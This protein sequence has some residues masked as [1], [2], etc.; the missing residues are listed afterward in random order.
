MKLQP[1]I[2]RFLSN[3]FFII[4]IVFMV[5]YYVYAFLVG[6]T[7]IIIYIWLAVLVLSI[8]L[9]RVTSAANRSATKLLLISVYAILSVHFVIMIIR[10]EMFKVSLILILLCIPI[11]F[12]RLK[13]TTYIY[14]AMILIF[15]ASRSFWEETIY[16]RGRGLLPVSLSF[17]NLFLFFIAGSVVV[18]E[19][20]YG[21]KFS[22]ESRFVPCNLYK[23]LLG[24][25][26]LF[27]FYAMWGLVSGVM[28]DSI[29]YNKGVINLTNMTILIFIIL[30]L[31]RTEKDFE[32]LKNFFMTCVAV[33]AVWIVYRFIF[34]T[35]DPGNIYKW[36]TKKN[37]PY[38]IAEVTMFDIGDALVLGTGVFYALWSL[39]FDKSLSRNKR[40]VYV[41]VII[42]SIYNMI[43]SY[44]R[45]IW[46]GFVIL[47]TWLI[48]SLPAKKRLMMG[49]PLLLISL[50]LLSG[51]ISK[52]SGQ[53]GLFEDIRSE[54]TGEITT[55][56]G[57]FS[58][59]DKAWQVIK[60]NPFVGVGPWAKFTNQYGS[61]TTVVHS[62][63]IYVWLKLGLIGILLYISFYYKYVQFWLTKRKQ[64]PLESRGF[65]EA[66]FAGFLFLMPTILF[67]PLINEFRTM[68]LL[69]L[70]I[71]IPYIGY[72]TYVKR[73]Q[74]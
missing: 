64:L 19:I 55:E 57:R 71:A 5:T 72:H 13:A 26:I 62:S 39:L 6:Q 43:F 12:I 54:S 41:V 25:N 67:S 73:R 40:L 9:T 52:R 34:M 47:L 68:S 32:R 16:D 56:E 45:T 8:F 20:I 3:L 10:S 7:H 42:L 46:G 63:I 21:T 22:S 24:F 18:K 36:A 49:I 30:Y 53:L 58:E 60:K 37:K 70:C 28:P 15:Q 44:R 11:L 48:F 27:G 50:V 4:F 66:A 31:F 17:M 29:F 59:L 61:L 14:L 35:G 69:G 51:V 65:A 33:K 1:T 38:G 2:G 74:L 23:H